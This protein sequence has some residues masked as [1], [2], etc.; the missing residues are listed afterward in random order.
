MKEKLFTLNMVQDPKVS[1]V[2]T[3]LV[4]DLKVHF[5]T[6]RLPTTALDLWKVHWAPPQSFEMFLLGT[7]SMLKHCAGTSGRMRCVWAQTVSPPRVTFKIW[8][9]PPESEYQYGSEWHSAGSISTNIIMLYFACTQF[10]WLYR[11][12]GIQHRS[13]VGKKKNKTQGHSSRVWYARTAAPSSVSSLK[14]EVRDHINEIMQHLWHTN[15]VKGIKLGHDGGI[16]IHDMTPLTLAA[17][18]RQ[19]HQWKYSVSLHSERT[20]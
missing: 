2:S 16:K 9:P 14:I 11:T 20:Y 4:Q 19:S 15:D 18:I 13:W 17:E 10:V 1:K 12:G 3:V 5:H 7:K 8:S 6:A